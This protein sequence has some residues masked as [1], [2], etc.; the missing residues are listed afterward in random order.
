MTISELYETFDDVSDYTRIK[1]YSSVLNGHI[2]PNQL[3]F[4]GIFSAMSIE[5]TKAHVVRFSHDYSQDTL[6]VVV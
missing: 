3:I 4:S 1:V 6:F 2:M 5:L